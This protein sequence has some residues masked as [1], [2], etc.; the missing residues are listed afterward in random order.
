MLVEGQ[1][2]ASRHLWGVLGWG[3]APQN[4]TR[5]QI[6]IRNRPYNASYALRSSGVHVRIWISSV[7]QIVLG[8]LCLSFR[9]YYHI[10]GVHRWGR[11][12]VFYLSCLSF[13]VFELLG[14]LPDARGPPGCARIS[15]RSEASMIVWAISVASCG[16]GTLTKHS[17][18]ALVKRTELFT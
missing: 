15:I 18:L 2:I 12:P 14:S 5:S 11:H 17:A 7:F 8:P 3:R 6:D 10:H 4:P 9:P 1:T 13:H 16:I